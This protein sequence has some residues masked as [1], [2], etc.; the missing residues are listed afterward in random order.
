LA[1]VGNPPY[2]VIQLRILNSSSCPLAALACVRGQLMKAHLGF[3]TL[4]SRFMRSTRPI[5]R[6]RSDAREHEV[7]KGAYLGRRQMP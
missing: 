1:K 3:A 7:E 5:K 6:R 2:A 4:S